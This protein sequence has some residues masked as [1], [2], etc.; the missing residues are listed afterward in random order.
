MAYGNIIFDWD[1]VF[2]NTP[3]IWQESIAMAGRE[4]NLTFTPQQIRLQCADLLKALEHGVP[5]RSYNAYTE[6]VYGMAEPSVRKAP[7][8]PGTVK[9]LE[10]L[11]LNGKRLA[12]VSA[13]T[14]V[15]EDVERTGMSRFFDIVLSGKDVTKRK[16]DPEG[17]LRA[18]D[19]LKAK[20]NDSV[21]VGDAATDIMAASA[22]GVS[23]ILYHPRGHSKFHDIKELMDS[24]PTHTVTSN[25]QLL[26]LLTV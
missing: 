15:T 3:G 9:M 23:S 25:A 26:T 17:V 12:I 4:L 13:R 10:K 8:Y 1:G 24:K 19:A 6:R 11:K 5:E 2:V 22:A 16:P 18:L 21:L 7:L 14:S 20:K